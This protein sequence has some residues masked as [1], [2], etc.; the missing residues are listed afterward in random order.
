LKLNKFIILTIFALNTSPLLFAGRTT[1]GTTIAASSSSVD[2]GGAD[3]VDTSAST[4]TKT[5]GLNV[6]GSVGIGTSAPTARLA[7]SSSGINLFEVNNASTVFK[8]AV[9]ARG[10]PFTQGDLADGDKFLML[11]R[12]ACSRMSSEGGIG[13]VF[14]FYA[15]CADD[16]EP[17]IGISN[18]GGF[19]WKTVG[20]T[21]ISETRMT[22]TNAGN[23]GIGTAVPSGR[24]HVS[25]GNF[26]VTGGSSTFENSVYIGSQTSSGI[27]LDVE[28]G[29]NRYVFGKFG[30][31]QPA[32]ISASVGAVVLGFNQYYDLSLFRGGKG[33][34]RFGGSLFFNSANGRLDWTVS[35][36]TVAA[37]G[38]AVNRDVFSATALGN[39]GIGT[40]APST[41]LHVSTAAGEEGALMRV[42]SG[43]THIFEVSGSSVM[44]GSNLIVKGVGV[45][46]GAEP[47]S[48]VDVQN[49]SITVRGI[50]A[51]LEIRRT[52]AAAT[53]T[54]LNQ[55]NAA[56]QYAG[57]V[58][59]RQGDETWFAGIN[60]ANDFYRFRAL[61][62][63]DHV[64]ISTSGNVGI[65]TN[66]PTVPV[67][68]FNTGLNHVIVNRNSAT[69]GPQIKFQ[70]QGVDKWILKGGNN[71]GTSDFGLIEANGS[72]RI[73]VTVGGNVGLGTMTPS[74]RFYVQSGSITVR[75]SGAGL[76]VDQLGTSGSAANVFYNTT[77]GSFL[78]STSSRR[79]KRDIQP[80]FPSGSDDFYA[81][82]DIEP[83]T[84]LD[85]EPAKV[86]YP[87]GTFFQIDDSKNK[88]STKTE[89]KKIKEKRE[90]CEDG[91]CREIE[92]E[93]EVTVT[94]VTV[95]S[96]IA[97][98]EFSTQPANLWTLDFSD[99]KREIG[100]MAEDVAAVAPD[101]AVYDSLGR[102]DG[103]K[104]GR[105]WVYFLP[106][107]KDQKTRI[108]NLET[109]VVS[110]QAQIDTL[111]QA[112][113]KAVSVSPFC[114]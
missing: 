63:T 37:D 75:G 50:N 62:T 49:G 88:I 15:G 79:Y 39:F 13:F 51:G 2:C 60:D 65:G 7:V 70:M 108:E 31:D 23:L 54:R 19:A 41:R 45:G 58:L 3:C 78:R 72:T 14:T 68:T 59:A 40:T 26:N 71:S 77:D 1:A 9:L 74:S 107:L 10:Y 112:F 66:H 33:S 36:S 8:T 16:P 85:V 52:D 47:S 5:G 4:Q 18:T 24:L 46:I 97:T 6:M 102:P 109:V 99:A 20:P 12:P 106:I 44:I 76:A 84:F 101:L 17:N 29:R 61:G 89:K 103:I 53:L 81:V 95:P 93:K 25:S 94:T 91:V 105:A 67:E 113:C 32:Y 55:D 73:N 110:Q 56:L 57:T 42:S 28:K 80:L 34:P 100:A 11:S 21:T 35:N 48:R 114:Q 86:K 27:G 43:T 104:D 30:N 82:L 90:L 92:T 69:V 22:L 111:K 96:N 87:A 98:I 83:K 64:V 38:I